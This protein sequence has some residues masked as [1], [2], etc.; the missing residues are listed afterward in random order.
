MKF[1]S[2]SSKFDLNYYY[3]GDLQQKNKKVPKIKSKKIIIVSR[4]QLFNKLL[5]IIYIP[6]LF[7]LGKYSHVAT[8]LLSNCCLQI[9]MYLTN[10]SFCITSPKN[11]PHATR[12]P[13]NFYVRSNVFS[14]R[15]LFGN[16]RDTH[17]HYDSSRR[18]PWFCFKS[19]NSYVR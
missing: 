13:L 8:H 12:S 7:F 17:P 19:L 10:V 11:S 4:L 16:F 1:Q 14:L 9:E 2:K 15:L 3:I 5:L 6:H 18:Y